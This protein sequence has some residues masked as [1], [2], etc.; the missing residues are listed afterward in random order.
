MLIKFLTYKGSL[1]SLE[2]T[3]QKTRVQDKQLL[4]TLKD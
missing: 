1:T 3:G 4:G 2:E